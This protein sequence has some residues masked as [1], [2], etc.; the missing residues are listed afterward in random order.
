LLSYVI[1]TQGKAN[2]PT[3]S[4]RMYQISEANN[5]GE[6]IRAAEIEVLS[7]DFIENELTW[8]DITSLA[9]SFCIEFL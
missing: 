2:A 4:I 9:Y 3:K 1:Q 5:S 7:I 6:Q 8:Y